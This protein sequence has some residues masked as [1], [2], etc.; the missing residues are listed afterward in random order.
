MTTVLKLKLNK[1]S[2]FWLF[3]ILFIGNGATEVLT[4][5][6][7]GESVV[8]ITMLFCYQKCCSIFIAFCF[9]FFFLWKTIKVSR[10][11]FP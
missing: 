2:V 10:Y 3:T 5:P 4:A 7:E 6:S 11:L 9:F 1:L 8:T